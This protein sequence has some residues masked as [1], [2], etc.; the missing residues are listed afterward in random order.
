M[1]QIV[2]KQF[3][4]SWGKNLFIFFC[5]VNESNLGPTLGLIIKQVK[6]K[7]NNMFMNKLVNTRDRIKKYNTTYLYV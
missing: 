1:N 4:F 7:Y 6:L 5:L 3:E 2:Y